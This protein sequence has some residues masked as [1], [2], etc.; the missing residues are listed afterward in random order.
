MAAEAQN[1]LNQELLR[2]PMGRRGEVGR[3]GISVWR[4]EWIVAGE[5]VVQ[6]TGVCPCALNLEGIH[7]EGGPW[8]FALFAMLT[9]PQ[10]FDRSS[11]QSHGR[12]PQH[13]AAVSSS[14]FLSPLPKPCFIPKAPA[15]PPFLDAWVELKV[16]YKLKSTCYDMRQC[17]CEGLHPG[18]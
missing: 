4:R 8:T 1:I 7:G 15:P 9:R 3:R 18:P 14:F 13:H 11:P 12:I 17:V 16:N 6:I 2:L 10:G 5:V